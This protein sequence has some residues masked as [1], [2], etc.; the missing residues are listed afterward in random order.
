MRTTAPRR[1]RPAAPAGAAPAAAP[2]AAVRQFRRV[3]DLRG[4][5]QVRYARMIS[6]L[7]V[8][9]RVAFLAAV[10][11]V[12]LPGTGGT[13]ASAVAVTVVIAAPLLR[14][15]W[16]A[17]RWYRRG[18]RRYAVVAVSLLAVVASGSVIA[19]VTR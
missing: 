12:L 19:V 13:A 14:V 1:R 4:P 6:A 3:I 15:A 10:A 7:S 18:D 8:L 16:L 17:I 11:G 9:T 5:E 2:A